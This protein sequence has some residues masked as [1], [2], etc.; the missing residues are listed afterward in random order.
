MIAITS[1]LPTALATPVLRR[2]RTRRSDLE[3]RGARKT[4][5]GV[6]GLPTSLLCETHSSGA[7]RREESL[8]RTT[9]TTSFTSPVR[10]IVVRLVVGDSGL[11]TPVGLDVI[12]LGVSGSWVVDIGYVLTGRRVGRVVVVRSAVGDVFLAP[13][14]GVDRVDV[15]VLSVVARI[16][17]L[18][19]AGSVVGLVVIRTVG[20]GDVFLAPPVGVDR[21]DVPVLSVVARIGYLGAAR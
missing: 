16:G 4:R 7:T 3:Q 10:I 13:P 18:G 9:T 12:D 20:V 8:P 2:G 1:F 6:S 21:V 15:P 5:D 14:V 17:Y 11:T 19:A